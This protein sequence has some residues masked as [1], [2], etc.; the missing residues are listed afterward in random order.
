VRGKRSPRLIEIFPK[1]RHSYQVRRAIR[2]CEIAGL[3]LASIAIHA[4]VALLPPNLPVTQ[5]IDIDT[6]VLGFT[7]ARCLV[8]LVTLAASY[9]PARRA[10]RVNPIAVLRQD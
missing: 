4:I 10:C 9:A 7:S 1:R 5:S 3:W 2:P 8:I 6:T